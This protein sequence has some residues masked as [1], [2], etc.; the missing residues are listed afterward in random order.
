MLL[1]RVFVYHCFVGVL[2]SGMRGWSILVKTSLQLR[3]N[4]T[5]FIVSK[6]ALD[7]F[8]FGPVHLVAFF[9]WTGPC[10]RAL[11]SEDQEGRGKGFRPSLPDG[12][13]RVAAHSVWELPVVPVQHQLLF[14]NVFCLLDSAWLS[15]LKYEQDAP[16]K[17]AISKAPPHGPASSSSSS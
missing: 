16:W 7:T 15:W 3:P 13:N 2:S 6:L 1:L 12:S 14:V 4:M 11:A 9:T 5:R 17:V 10:F 8:I